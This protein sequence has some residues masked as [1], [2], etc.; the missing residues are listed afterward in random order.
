[1]HIKA[2]IEKKI[3]VYVCMKYFLYP[4]MH[5]FF[6]YPYYMLLLFVFTKSNIKKGKII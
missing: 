6:N 1:M 4:Y 2:L 5:D 3:C